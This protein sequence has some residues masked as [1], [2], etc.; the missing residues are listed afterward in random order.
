MVRASASHQCGPRFALNFIGADHLR[1]P[2]V[3]ACST[4]D[5]ATV[6]VAGGGLSTF[7]STST[8]PA[9]PMMNLQSLAFLLLTLYL[10]MSTIAGLYLRANALE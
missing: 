1:V 10:S 4:D 9:T 5:E 2:R 8:V 3:P 7:H 6:F